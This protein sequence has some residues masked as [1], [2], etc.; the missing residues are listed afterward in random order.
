MTYQEYKALGGT[1][2][3]GAYRRFSFIAEKLI[4]S[5]VTGIDGVNKLELYPP[6]DLSAIDFLTVELVNF[7]NDVAVS[8]A[9]GGSVSSMSSGSES[10]S[11]SSGGSVAMKAASDAV[12][13]AQYVNN[14]IVQ[15]LSG[16]KDSNGVNML[17]RGCYPCR[18]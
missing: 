16:L 5:Y 14:L 1:A 15:Y 2:D 3:E 11:Y 17:Y 8:A 18:F 9:A 10:V 7:K 6:E 4:A 13:E 12:I